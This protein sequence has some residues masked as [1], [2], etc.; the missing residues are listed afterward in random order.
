[1]CSV[2]KK[3]NHLSISAKYKNNKMGT[4]KC[5]MNMWKRP[6]INI[7]VDT[8]MTAFKLKW[9]IYWLH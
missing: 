4:L 6:S 3:M 1:M 8:S 5:F 2:G 9:K 7:F